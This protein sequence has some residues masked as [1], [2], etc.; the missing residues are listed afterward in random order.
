MDKEII[1]KKIR[2]EKAKIGQKFNV[3]EIGLFGSYVKNEQKKRSDI[4][5]LV[6]FSKPIGWDVV[7]LQEYLQSVLG[8]RVDLV[9]KKG[10]MRNKKLWK[11]V[12]PEVI[13]V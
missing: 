4:D 8:I 2:R 6:D 1:I 5:I 10:L 13:Y 9:L 3:K 11:L 7:E 12:K